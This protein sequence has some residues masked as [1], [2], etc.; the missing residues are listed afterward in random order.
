M[1]GAAAIGKAPVRGCGGEQN[2][3]HGQSVAA[4]V[5]SVCAPWGAARGGKAQRLFERV[6]EPTGGQNVAWQPSDLRGQS[7]GD[8]LSAAALTDPRAAAQ[9][10][11]PL[12]LLVREPCWHDGAYRR[13]VGALAE[14]A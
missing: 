1:A 8:A 14:A 6:A 9:T 10:G 7:S 5:P 2:Q 13:Q 3:W 4:P 11:L 12:R